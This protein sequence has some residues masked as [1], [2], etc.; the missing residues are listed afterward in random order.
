MRAVALDPDVAVGVDE[1]LVDRRRRRAA[2]SSAPRPSRRATAAR[3]SRSP[4][5]GAGE[6]RDAPEVGA[7][8]GVGVAVA[9]RSAARHSSST[10]R[11]STGA[12]SCR[13]PQL[14]GEQPG[15]AGGEQP[16]VD[17][18]GDRR[19]RWLTV[20][21][22]GAP[23][24]RSTSAARRPRPGSATSTT[25]SGRHGVADGAPQGEV[26]GAGDEQRCA[27]RRRAGLG[28]GG[29]VPA[30]TTTAY[31]RS[32]SHADELGP[33]R[34][35]RRSTGR[36]PRGISR[37]VRST[38]TARSASAPG[39]ASDASQSATPWPVGSGRPSTA[40]SSPSRSTS[41]E[42]VGQERASVA[43]TTVVP[44]PPFA[45]QQT[46]TGTGDLPGWAR[47]RADGIPGDVGGATVPKG[48]ARSNR[49]PVLSAGIGP[50]GPI[51]ADRL[52]SSPTRT[53]D[54][55]EVDGNRTRRTGITRP[56][57]FEGGGAHQVPGH[58]PGAHQGTPVD[59][60]RRRS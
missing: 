29:P 31:G 13:T 23:I 32:A 7:H 19:D 58:L 2:A 21:T 33:A 59:R 3:T 57:R 49:H 15:Q 55:A 54:V 4:S 43:A 40:G 16:G 6:R 30:S 10:S 22:T 60:V 51:A 56:N 41:S 37:V 28:G 34:R 1:H 46:V 26:A 52:M 36:V 39:G 35:E 25:P 14:A 44:L 45:A 5:A 47:W 8:D 27:R 48:C 20:A 50:N 38:S 9:R 11:S 42:S 24:A 17:G 18:A 53:A 12:R